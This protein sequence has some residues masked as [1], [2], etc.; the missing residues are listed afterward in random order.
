MKD[1]SLKFQD[2]SFQSERWLN[3]R[4]SKLIVAG[5]IGF[6]RKPLILTIL[7]GV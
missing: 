5:F 3:G 2:S 1:S 7:D 6:R 4:R